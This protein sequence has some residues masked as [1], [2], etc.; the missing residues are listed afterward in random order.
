MT[1]LLYEHYHAAQM[2]SPKAACLAARL[3]D[4]AVDISFEWRLTLRMALVERARGVSGF[5]TTDLLP[6]RP[7]NPA[8]HGSLPPHDQARLFMQAVQT[9]AT[10][11]HVLAV[12]GTPRAGG[13]SSS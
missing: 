10:E 12:A 5:S 11:L 4:T 8:G 13:M 2:L 9:D 7:A 3:L 6:L 1:M